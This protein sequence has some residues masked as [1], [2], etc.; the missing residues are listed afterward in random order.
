MDSVSVRRCFGFCCGCGFEWWGRV[1]VSCF[2][3]GSE[4]FSE[5]GDAEAEAEAAGGIVYPSLAVRR[6]SF[7]VLNFGAEVVVCSGGFAVGSFAE[8]GVAV[9]FV[10]R[11]W[12]PL[13]ERVGCWLLALALPERRRV[14]GIVSLCMY[15]WMGGCGVEG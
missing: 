14:G 7:A 5:D 11:D 8:R 3:E 10:M 1:V 2:G 13:K 12:V 4:S 9:G 15:V 6:R